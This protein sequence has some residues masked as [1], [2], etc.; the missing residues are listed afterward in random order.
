MDWYPWLVLT[1]VIGAFGFAVSHGV[2]VFAAFRLRVEPDRARIEA[3]L[4]LSSTSLA[5]LYA[6]LLVLLAGGISAGFVGAWWDEAWIW[7]S[8]GILVVVLVV[9]WAVASPYYMGL[10]KGLGRDGR[11]PKP[12]D[13]PLVPLTDEELLARLRSSRPFW[14]AAVGGIGLVAI[15][16]LMVLKPF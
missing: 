10:R 6:S 16:W 1:H 13:P 8:I 9:M 5:L 3:L 7:V 12:G 14:L 2:S 4:D 11:E 15:I